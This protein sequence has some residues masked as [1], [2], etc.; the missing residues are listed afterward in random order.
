MTVTALRITPVNVPMTCTYGT[1]YPARS[2]TAGLAIILESQSGLRGES[3]LIGAHRKQMRVLHEMMRCL[4]PLVVGTD[5]ADWRTFSPRARDDSK[6][7]GHAGVVAIGIGAL[8]AS[9]LDLAAKASD[10]PV[11]RFLGAKREAVRAYYSSGFWP[12]VPLD[13]MLKT[14]QRVIDAGYRAIKV[15]VGGLSR[16]DNVRRLT[17]LREAVGP[18]V[19]IM[20]DA[21][22]RLDTDSAIA[23]GQALA[24]LSIGWLEEPIAGDDHAANAAIAAAIPMP[25][26]LGESVFSQ[27]EFE[28]ILGKRAA[29]VIMPDL[30][31]IG[32]PSAFLAIA[33]LTHA[34]GLAISSHVAPEMSLSLLAHVENPGYVEIMPW[35][36]P[37]Y[38]DS[39]IVEDGYAKLSGAP[40]WGVSLSD[41]AIARYVVD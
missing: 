14:A 6:H 5:P 17:A 15:R 32:G 41:E 12:S 1:P 38:R 16:D 36:A 25:V 23:L 19:E 4:E 22:R 33:A 11:H 18:D 37:L 21:G 29:K 7:V 9:L 39:I 27:A 10:Q 40:G 3:V 26:A 8:E 30:Q 24:P 34:N 31:R 13:V 2:H 20:L 35:A 28:D